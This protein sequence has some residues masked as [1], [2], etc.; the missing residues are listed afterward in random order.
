[1]YKINKPYNI[2]NKL[3]S[4]REIFDGIEPKFWIS[5]DETEYLYKYNPDFEDVTFG[6]VF[7]SAL[8]KSLGIWTAPGGRPPPRRQPSHRRRI[9]FL[10]CTLVFPPH[11]LG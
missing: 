4:R 10:I 1:M 2:T 3:K 11:M 7:I 6:E 9:Q 5:I 8:C